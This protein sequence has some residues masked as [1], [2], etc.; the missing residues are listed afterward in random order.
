MFD[1]N[2]EGPNSPT[3]IQFMNKGVVEVIKDDIFEVTGEDI[4]I[5][6]DPYATASMFWRPQNWGLI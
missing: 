6:N 4:A 3:G 1:L 5:H 2:P